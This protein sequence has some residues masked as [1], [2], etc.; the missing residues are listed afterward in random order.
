MKVFIVY[1]TNAEDGTLVFTVCNTEEKAKRIVETQ[2]N[3]NWFTRYYYE[4][5]EVI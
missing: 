4:E 3:A 5:W 2:S 1:E